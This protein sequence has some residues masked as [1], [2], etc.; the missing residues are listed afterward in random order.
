MT[1]SCKP[2]MSV[3]VVAHQPNSQHLYQPLNG[4]HQILGEQPVHHHLYPEILDVLRRGINS[5]HQIH[6][7]LVRTA[8]VVV[9]Y[10]C[11][12]IYACI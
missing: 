4:Y 7:I 10:S 6:K 12:C 11:K 3:F 8:V 5:Y 9:S 1:W 2:L